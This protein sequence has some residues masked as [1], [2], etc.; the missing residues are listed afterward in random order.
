MNHQVIRKREILRT[1]IYTALDQSQSEAIFRFV[2]NLAPTQFLGYHVADYQE[3]MSGILADTCRHLLTIDGNGSVVGYM[4]YREKSGPYGVVINSLPFFGPN[5]LILA[6]DE[7]VRRHLLHAFKAEM[8]Q[9]HVLSAVIY[10]PFLESP[11]LVTSILEPNHRI[12]KFTQYVHLPSTLKWPKKRRGDLRRADAGN[13]KLREATVDDADDLYQIYSENCIE[14]GIPQKPRAYIDLTITQAVG[15]IRTGR[16]YQSPWPKPLWLVAEREGCVVAGLLAMRGIYT[17][18][19]TI[20]LAKASVRSEQPLALLIDAAILRAKEEGL[21]FWN[22]ESSPQRDDNVFKY[23]ER[24][25]ASLSNYEILLYYPN[26][27]DHVKAIEVDELRR[28]Y[29]FYYVRPYEL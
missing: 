4:P 28:H 19:Y 23:K 1:T 11:T 13:F 9:D 25:G 12:E 24:W 8:S 22:F 7:A 15:L 17:M 18:S 10:T 20:P 26:G 21:T 29:P 2:R 3:S 5:S 6:Q 14:A 16:P 27:I